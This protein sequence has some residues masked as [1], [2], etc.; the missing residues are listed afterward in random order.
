VSLAREMTGRLT[1]CFCAVDVDLSSHRCQGHR[2][3]TM[4]SYVQCPIS[5]FHYVPSNWALSD[6]FSK[7]T[8]QE[9]FSYK[10]RAVS[11][12]VPRRP[13]EGQSSSSATI[14]SPACRW[15]RL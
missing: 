14:H 7:H 2:N 10:R 4:Q 8:L 11:D 13:L 9:G 12:S 6:A 5:C 3:T 15:R 1:G